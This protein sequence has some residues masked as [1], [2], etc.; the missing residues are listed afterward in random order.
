MSEN[1]ERFS[2]RDFAEAMSAARRHFGLSRRQIEYELVSERKVG[3]AES[4]SGLVEIEAWP[5][6][7]AQPGSQPPEPQGGS[8]REHRDE[9][10]DRPR[11]EGSG[12]DRR[13]RGDR[14]DRGDRADSGD[15]GGRGRREEEP[16]F[17]MPPLF[18][19][20]GVEDK[21][22]II[23][24]LTEGLIAGLALDLEVEEIVENPVGIRVNLSGEDTIELLDA[25]AE[26]LDALQYLANRLL[27]KDGRLGVRV[28]YDADGH[29][30]AIE[31]RLI[32]DARQ[33]A[34]EVLE[35]GE[36][37]KMSPMG[38]YE[39]RLVHIALSEIPGLHTYST[40]GGYARRLHITREEGQDRGGAGEEGSEAPEDAS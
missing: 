35:T 20:E 25:D 29:R 10:R 13:D 8:P 32:E 40:G 3:P 4:S 30:A 14:G 39:R 12:R 26:G 23:R 28:S 24:T 34:D 5:A 6:E 38:P 1:R 21:P 18:P 22:T 7:G 19:E 11:R 15:R 9:G 33:L 17:E 37:R 36:A 27:Q 16:S 2:G 31:K